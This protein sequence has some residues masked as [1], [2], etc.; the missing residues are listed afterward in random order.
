MAFLAYHLH[1]D[2]DRLL[3]LEHGDRIRLL[4]EVGGLN[5]RAWQ[6]VTGG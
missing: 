1:W 2:L 6:G 3:D 5:E 4:R